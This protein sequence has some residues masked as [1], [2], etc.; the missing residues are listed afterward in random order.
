[1]LKKP[2]EILPPSAVG[3]DFICSKEEQAAYEHF[4]GVLHAAA[5]FVI[6]VVSVKVALI[7]F[8]CVF[9]LYSTVFRARAQGFFGSLALICLFCLLCVAGASS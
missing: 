8:F 7:Y 5:P 9:L 4:K 6:G 1:M 2:L 3:D